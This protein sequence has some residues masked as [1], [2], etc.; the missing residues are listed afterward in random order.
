MNNSSTSDTRAPPL[1]TRLDGTRPRQETPTP[2]NLFVETIKVIVEGRIYR[3]PSYHLLTSRMIR[4][5]LQIIHGYDAEETIDLTLLANREDFENLIEVLYPSQ[6]TFDRSLGGR[7]WLSALKL[8]TRLEMTATR[9]ASIYAIM[10]NAVVDMSTMEKVLVGHAH[11]VPS[12]FCQGCEESVLRSDTP[13][14]AELLQLKGLGARLMLLREERLQIELQA[15]RERFDA[16]KRVGEIF[17]EDLE[18]LEEI[19][20]WMAA[21][22]RRSSEGGVNG[23]SCPRDVDESKEQI[24]KRARMN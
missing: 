6:I 2:S 1:P 15:V 16:A 21:G 19:E 13:S 12:L 11:G 8:A 20:R 24:A 4:E 9:A 5:G 22:G 17:K 7:V 3:V 18:K 23:E 10:H 14:L